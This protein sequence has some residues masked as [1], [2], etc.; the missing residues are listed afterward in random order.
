MQ[1]DF[2]LRDVALRYQ[3]VRAVE[4]EVSSVQCGTIITRDGFESKSK[5]DDRISKRGA[6]SWSSLQPKVGFLTDGKRPEN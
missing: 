1:N 5:V 4:S 6:G 2:P 3:T